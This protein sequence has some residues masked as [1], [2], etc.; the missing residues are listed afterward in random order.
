[1]LSNIQQTGWQVLLQKCLFK[2][3]FYV[4]MCHPVQLEKVFVPVTAENE[5]FLMFI[6]ILIFYFEILKDQDQR[7]RSP[8][9]I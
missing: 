7:S 5:K 1:M 4:T 9:V 8:S 3:V 6:V 2:V